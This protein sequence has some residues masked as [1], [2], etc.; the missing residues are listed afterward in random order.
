[1]AVPR[2]DAIVVC[3]CGKRW[4][5][6]SRAAA[7]EEMEAVEHALIAAEV[8]MLI[9]HFELGHEL[10]LGENAPRSFLA[11]VAEVARRVAVARDRGLAEA[12]RA[13]T[14]R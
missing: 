2:A 6:V 14:R 10:K 11:V 3:S 1:M 8:P 9:R 7:C 4:G 5:R 12:P 13:P